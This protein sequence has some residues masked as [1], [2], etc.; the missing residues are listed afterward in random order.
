[1]SS[2]QVY[3]ALNDPWFDPVKWLVCI[4]ICMQENVYAEVKWNLS[5]E[6]PCRPYLFI[7]A[8]HDIEAGEEIVLNNGAQYWKVMAKELRQ[9]HAQEWAEAES[10]RGSAGCCKS[11][12]WL[13]KCVK[14]KFK[15]V[16]T[17]T[18]TPKTFSVYD[19]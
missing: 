12:C 15:A 8:Y 18:S 4:C 1:M 6:R 14:Q 13:M 17:L 2:Q 9:A 5:P 7:V 11:F 10:S 16:L 3:E 19:V